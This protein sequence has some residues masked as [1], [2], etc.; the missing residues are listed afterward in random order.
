MRS[1]A[2]AYASILLT[3]LS[4]CVTTPEAVRDTTVINSGVVFIDIPTR[5]AATGAAPNDICSDRGFKP[6]PIIMVQG[7]EGYGLDNRLQNAGDQVMRMG[8]GCTGGDMDQCGLVAE[9]LSDWARAG[10][11]MVRRSNKDSAR[12]WNDT[13][14]VNLGIVRPFIGAYSIARARGAGDIGSDR[15]IQVWMRQ[16]V[17]EASHLMRNEKPYSR[18]AAAG[19]RKAAH[20]HAAASGAAWMAYGAQWGDDAAFQHGVDQWFI[21]LG[22]MRNDGSL[23]IETRRG[24]RAI[25]YQG[26]AMS[27]LASIAVMAQQQ[28]LDLW[29]MGPSEDKDFH[30]VVDFIINAL[31][32]PDVVLKYARENYVPGPSKDW[33]NQHLGGL[34]NTLGW[35][36]PYVNRFPSHPNTQRIFDAGQTEGMGMKLTFPLTHKSLV[37]DWAGV[38]GACAYRGPY[39]RK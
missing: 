17:Q 39:L 9:T 20:N 12:Y 19:S 38:D 6:A 3:L 21:T 13:L 30:K 16:V 28:G 7:P 26:R 23:P 37:G 2:F 18:G 15:G 10:A 33:R 8:S 14:S 11:V 36:L 22:S 35:V 25:F 4:A 1:R 29:S 31:Q 24:A 5:D 27:A 32:N 34:A